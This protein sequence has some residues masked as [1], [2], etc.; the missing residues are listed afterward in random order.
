MTFRRCMLS[1]EDKL[2][3]SQSNSLHRFHG[4][5]SLFQAQWLIVFLSNTALLLKCLDES[6]YVLL[7]PSPMHVSGLGTLVGCFALHQWNRTFSNIF[8]F[9]LVL[10]LRERKKCV[11]VCVCVCVRV[12]VC[13]CVCV[14]TIKCH[15]M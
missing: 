15:F 2:H 11:C 5:G 14:P 13:V 12:C 6:I 9:L 8:I 7:F 1:R 3:T 10:K 4:N